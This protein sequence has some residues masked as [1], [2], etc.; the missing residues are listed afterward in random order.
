VIAPAPLGGRIADSC[1]RARRQ[2]DADPKC[3]YDDAVDE[4]RQD[5]AEGR[6]TAN[7]AGIAIVLAL[8]VVGLILTRK[9]A[10]KSKLEDCL[11]ARRTN[12]VSIE[13]PP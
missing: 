7:L 3:P 5:D 12:C 10:E 2:R 4:N 6:T 1:V 8:V 9:L 11:L 13:V